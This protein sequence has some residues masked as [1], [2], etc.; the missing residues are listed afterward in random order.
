MDLR[1]GGA[2]GA[3]PKRPATIDEGLENHTTAEKARVL[4]DLRGRYVKAIAA[5]YGKAQGKAQVRA[6]RR[7]A[8]L[9]AV[10]GRKPVEP[11]GILGVLK[12]GGYERSLAEWQ[13]EHARAYRLMDQAT[14]LTNRIAAAGSKTEV[15]HL[16]HRLTEKAAPESMREVKAHQRAQWEAAYEKG[17]RE[18]EAERAQVR[19]RD[20]GRGR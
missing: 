14:G 9:D 5:R 13:V 15:D 3:W 18:K 20:L 17:E 16:A 4:D 12:R 10:L 8:R 7:Q 11:R 1:T 2:T 19:G 6:Q